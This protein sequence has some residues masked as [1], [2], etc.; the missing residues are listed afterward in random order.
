[1]RIRLDAL[2]NR[3]VS[4]LDYHIVDNRIPR[5]S[6]LKDKYFQKYKILVNEIPHT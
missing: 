6:I 2:A 4:L 1:M 5:E 3:T